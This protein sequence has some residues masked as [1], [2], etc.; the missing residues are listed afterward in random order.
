MSTFRRLLCAKS[1]LMQCSKMQ[2]IRSPRRRGRAAGAGIAA[3]GIVATG[4]S[5]DRRILGAEST[6][7]RH[8]G[9]PSSCPFSARSG[10]RPA[11]RK[12][13]DGRSRRTRPCRRTAVKRHRGQRA[14]AADSDCLPSATTAEFGSA[15][16]CSRAARFGVSPIIA[17]SLAEPDPI[18]S[19]TTTRPVAVP[20][21]VRSKAG[22]LRRIPL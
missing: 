17:C 5:N 8:R 7:R 10:N 2:L 1:G 20:T 22:V 13:C 15:I 3:A 16:P 6:L 4:G 14:V 11:A 9:P 21:R 18:K 19:P 12:M